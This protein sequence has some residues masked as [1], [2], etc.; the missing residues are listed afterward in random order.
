MNDISSDDIFLLKQR[1]AEQEALIHALQEK[2]SNRGAR[3]RPS[4]GAA[5]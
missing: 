2:L 1:L 5:G 3:N 4:A